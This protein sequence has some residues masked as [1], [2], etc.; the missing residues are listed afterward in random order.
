VPV[1]PYPDA[2]RTRGARV[3]SEQRTGIDA[4]HGAAQGVIPRQS[5]AHTIRQRQHP[6]A[7]RYLWQHLVNQIGGALGHPSP[8]TAWTEAAALAREGHEALEG[9]VGAPKPREAMGQDPAREELAKL[10]LD[11]AGQ[12]VAVA[13][14]SDF[15]EEGLQV[16]ADDGVEDGVLGVAGLIRAVGMRHAQG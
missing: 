9:A 6:L 16:L 3:E 15:P 2:V 12:A 1:W 8:P 4:Q 10:L 13:A 11:E 5:G 14:V 7:H